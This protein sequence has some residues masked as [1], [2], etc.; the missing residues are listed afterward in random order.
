MTEPTTILSRNDLLNSIDKLQNFCIK[1]KKELSDMCSINNNTDEYMEGINMLKTD[2]LKIIN[3]INENDNIEDLSRFQDKK[4]CQK[5]S[6]KVYDKLKSNLDSDYMLNT[7]IPFNKV[8]TKFYIEIK[9]KIDDIFPY[10]ESESMK[11]TLYGSNYL[12]R[13]DIIKYSSIYLIEILNLISCVFTIVLGEN[14]KN[15]TQEDI[16]NSYF[17]NKLN[18]I[19]K[20]ENDEYIIPICNDNYRNITNSSDKENI[21]TQIE[22]LNQF[23]NLFL[24]E[25]E[26]IDE[27]SYK[28]KYEKLIQKIG[29][30]IKVDEEE[31]KTEEEEVKSKKQY[32]LKNMLDKTLL[33][34]QRSNDLQ[35]K[36]EEIKNNLLTEIDNLRYLY[37]TKIIELIIKLI[38][39]KEIP[40]QKNSL[41]I[42]CK[43]NENL[44]DCIERNISYVSD[45]L[46]FNSVKDLINNKVFVENN[47][48]MLK[49]QNND[50][51]YLMKNNGIIKDNKEYT[52]TR[53]LNDK[54]ES[55]IDSLVN[56]EKL[57]I[58]AKYEETTIILS[59]DNKKNQTVE[60]VTNGNWRINFNIDYDTFQTIKREIQTII[61]DLF[62]NFEDKYLSIIEILKK[63]Y[64]ERNIEDK[65]K[66][67]T[68]GKYI[69]KLS[70][71]YMRK[72]KNSKRKRNYYIKK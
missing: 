67:I 54:D 1:D 14:Y 9:K 32:K 60:E 16:D 17:I 2:L 26:V 13:E 41:L 65:S 42:Y 31:V 18:S 49:Y 24:R 56:I 19:L 44:N 22:V 61:S 47:N 21:T 20:K 3:S 29:E 35:I 4:I 53:I 63:A 50:V 10:C 71:K 68:G 58:E 34:H 43:Q 69:N 52:I 30:E 23:R 48:I 64:S 12:T 55:F 36:D 25:G 5:Y 59:Y 70:K 27:N 8:D 7:K 28:D 66:E 11:D 33:C 39:N 15:K 40:N 57:K 45:K 72:N 6:L 37:L 51:V 62:L 46:I 38:G